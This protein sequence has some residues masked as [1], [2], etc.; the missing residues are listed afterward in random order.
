MNP[1]LARRVSREAFEARYADSEDPW[2]F[3]TS[4]YERDRYGRILRALG[5]PTYGNVYEPGC[6]VGVLTAQ[7]ARLAAR[8]IAIDLAPTAVRQAKA[9]CAHLKNVEIRCESVATYCPSIPLDLVLF[10]ELGYYFATDELVRI[11]S[12][13][14]ESLADRGE[15]IAVHW[16]GHSA[17]HVLHGD[18]VHESL[19]SSLRLR[20]VNGESHD[21]FRIDCW[22]KS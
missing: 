19:R 11:S 20:W 3:A 2:H 9:R 8:V 10:S 5:R 7:L 14:A 17:D 4:D 16:L 6:S 12:A 1:E 21:K 13:L 15:F 22:V 18:V